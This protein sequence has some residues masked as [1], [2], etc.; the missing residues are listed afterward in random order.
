M[1]HNFERQPVC[2]SSP[3]TSTPRRINQP[4]TRQKMRNEEYFQPLVPC[5][6]LPS[7]NFPLA[8]TGHF[9]SQS[10]SEKDPQ[11]IFFNDLLHSIREFNRLHAAKSSSWKNPLLY[12]TTLCD[13]FRQ[14]RYCRFGARCWYAHGEHELKFVPRMSQYPTSE[15]IHEYLSHL[16]LPKSKLEEFINSAAQNAGLQGEQKNFPSWML[17]QP[18][19]DKLPPP[20]IPRSRAAI[21]CTNSPVKENF[22][23]SSPEDAREAFQSSMANDDDFNLYTSI[24]GTLDRSDGASRS[25]FLKSFR[26]FGDS[27]PLKREER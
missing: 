26:L 9:R 6:S 18:D 8:T 3:R 24:V 14:D 23:S 10:Q 27:Y 2:P 4:V 25:E 16:G 19:L 11:Q 5:Q 13:N 17:H 12:K 22:C 21:S 15:Y 7:V 20:F 1:H